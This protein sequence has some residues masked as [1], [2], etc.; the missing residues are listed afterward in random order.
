M[1][2]NSLPR[3]LLLAGLLF[4]LVLAQNTRSET[5]YLSMNIVQMTEFLDQSGFT[6]E[7]GESEDGE[8][9]IEIKLGDFDPTLYL[10][11]CNKSGQC[12]T[13]L[14]EWGLDMD[15]EVDLEVINQF[16]YD[17]M[18]VQAFLD[19]DQDPWITSALDLTGG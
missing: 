3:L 4:G 2:L 7:P 15:E 11:D 8:P 13:L 14:L 17:H 10:A 18:F 19:E 16:N 12:T 9:Y 6:T 1:L 5:V